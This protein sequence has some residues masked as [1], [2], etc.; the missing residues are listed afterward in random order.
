MYRKFCDRC[1]KEITPDQDALKKYEISR[2]PRVL[3][4]DL[5]VHLCNKC[6]DEFEKWLKEE[7]DG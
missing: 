3:H 7:S 2:M 6:E 1:G 4:V 5:T